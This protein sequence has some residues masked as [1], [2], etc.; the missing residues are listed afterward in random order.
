[1]LLVL[2]HAF[3]YAVSSAVEPVIQERHFVSQPAD[4]Q[5][6]RQHN[7]PIIN[8]R[9]MCK[10]LSAYIY[11]SSNCEITLSLSLSYFNHPF[12]FLPGCLSPYL[13]SL[14]SLLFLLFFCVFILALYM[15]S[16]FLV[17]YL[18]ISM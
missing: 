6:F 12:C 10:A 9:L 2:C 4:R 11:V 14:P 17:A 8:W 13:Q 3:G 1:M 18:W 15:F 16:S 5:C 7:T